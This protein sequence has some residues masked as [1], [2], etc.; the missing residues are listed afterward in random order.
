MTI[1]LINI[2]K[3]AKKKKQ[4]TNKREIMIMCLAFFFNPEF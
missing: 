4:C 3:I 1:T 2:R